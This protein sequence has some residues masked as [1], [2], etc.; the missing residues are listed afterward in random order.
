MLMLGLM[1]WFTRTRLSKTRP[2]TRSL[3]RPTAR[4]W[5]E[6]LETRDCPSDLGGVLTG[7]AASSA[8]VQSQP[9]APTITL[10]AT[11][12]GPDSLTLSGTVSADQPAGLVV[13]FTGAVTNT[14][15]TDDNGN[16]SLTVNP[17][18]V[19]DVQ[20]TTVDDYGQVSNTATATPTMPAAPTITL[21]AA[22]TGQN[23]WT[24]S[25]VVSADQ[26]A[27]LTVT[28][29]GATS[30]TT[31]TDS[32]GNY[33]VTVNAG[34][35]GVV[36]AATADANGQFSNSATLDLSAPTL[37]LVSTAD[38]QNSVTLSGKVSSAQPAGMIVTFTGPVNGTAVTDANGNYSLTTN[39]AYLG[40]VQATTTDAYGQQSNTAIAVIT[41]PPAPSITLVATT[42]GQNS[43]TLSGVVSAE[44]PAGMVV[45]L[46]GVVNA[47][48]VADS[49]GNY[50]LT[51]DTD[52]VGN[53]QATT[54]DVYA[55]E[56]NAATATLAAPAAPTITLFVTMNG[57]N[58]VTLSGVVSGDRTA[59]LIVTFTGA[60]NATAVTDSN[61]NY[62][63]TIDADNLGEVQ[64][65]TVDAFGQQSNVAT[66][67]L[68]AEAPVIT[69]FT[70]TNQSEVVT[71]TG[72]LTC[73]DAAGMAITIQG[74]PL[75]LQAG[76]QVKAGADGSFSYSFMQRAFDT[77]SVTASCIDCWGQQSNVAET[78]L[79]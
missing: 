30:A 70:W 23:S 76:V 22:I 36:Q 65:S 43:V 66:A 7:S 26:P 72:V 38:G 71:F 68:A 48:T 27:G 19:G 52:Q 39:A 46:S 5:L 3:P 67:A 75:A 35:L 40:D 18:Y 29:S 13:A 14:T 55:Q 60:V 12:N 32:Y 16:F 17:D 49:N 15:V 74:E 31:V 33:S 58:S 56:S 1:K 69:G 50:S 59:G 11:T 8:I 79:A 63:L 20:A 77:G 57:Q 37:S 78:Q 10:L 41:A 44:E 6:R 61:G 73:P 28:L 53:V 45:T 34:N 21:L 47:T 25:G 4:L 54:V 64:A 24:F 42:D 9:A 2:K 62:S 51:V